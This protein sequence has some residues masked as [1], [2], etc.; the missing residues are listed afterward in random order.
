MS[1]NKRIYLEYSILRGKMKGTIEAKVKLILGLLYFEKNLMIITGNAL[2][3]Y[4]RS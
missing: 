1:I 4:E 3:K 2:T